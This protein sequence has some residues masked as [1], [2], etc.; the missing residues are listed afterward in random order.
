MYNNDVSPAIASNVL[1]Q[2]IVKM[3]W[4]YPSL[5]KNRADCLHQL[6]CVNGNGYEWEGG[7]L[8]GIE[9]LGEGYPVRDPDSVFRSEEEEITAWKKSFKNDLHTEMAQTI[10]A[11]GLCRVREHNSKMRFRRENADLLA[12]VEGD[13]LSIYPLCEYACMAEVPDDIHRDYLA[14]IREMIFIIFKT[15]ANGIGIGTPYTEKEQKENIEFASNILTQ[16]S[17]R[18]PKGSEHEPT[19]YEEYLER[20]QELIEIS[21]QVTRE[22]LAEHKKEDEQ[23]KALLQEYNF[24]Q[25]THV[26]YSEGAYGSLKVVG[27]IGYL[28]GEYEVIS[29]DESL[30]EY[31]GWISKSSEHS[32]LVEEIVALI[33]EIEGKGFKVETD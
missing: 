21:R 17:Q 31:W 16:L 10:R 33:A 20:Q 3:I 19:S 13:R 29:Q 23:R 9:E 2:R 6:F 8:K 24:H 14:G 25:L 1:Y 12:L 26:I 27:H 30:S 18:F 15:P 7:V 11:E 5:F 4:E 22:C 32:Q 28:S